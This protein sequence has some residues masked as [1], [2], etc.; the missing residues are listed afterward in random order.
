MKLIINSKELAD[1]NNVKVGDEIEVKDRKGMPLDKYWRNRL[2]DAK[3]DGCVS[4]AK[5][6]SK[7]AKTTKEEA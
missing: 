3:I 6:K 5:A 2:K 1:I 4:I 7:T